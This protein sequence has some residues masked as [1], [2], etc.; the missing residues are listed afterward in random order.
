MDYPQLNQNN[1]ENIFLPLTE[2]QFEELFNIA[3]P[4]IESNKFP[5][6]NSNEEQQK[7]N[8]IWN[9]YKLISGDK[10]NPPCACSSTQKY[11]LQ[12][13]E[14]IRDFILIVDKRKE[15]LSTASKN[16]IQ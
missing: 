13:I 12:A 5:F 10:G 7:R 11:W 8:T 1:M 14:A 16:P 4:I 15:S 9:Y 2:E 3:D 6:G